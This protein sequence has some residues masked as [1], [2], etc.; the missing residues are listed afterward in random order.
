MSESVA[1]ALEHTGGKELEETVKFIRMIDKFFDTLN[2]TN[3]VNG[4]KKRKSFQSPYTSSNDFRIK[5][6]IFITY[7]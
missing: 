6:R 4:K 7:M 1:Y 3:L 5:V 2:V